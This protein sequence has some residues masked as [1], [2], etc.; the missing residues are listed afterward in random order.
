[1]EET[2]LTRKINGIQVIGEMVKFT[3]GRGLHFIQI[4]GPKLLPVVN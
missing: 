1:M 3:E 4:I 2:F